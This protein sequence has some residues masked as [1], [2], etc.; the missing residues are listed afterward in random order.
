MGTLVVKVKLLL[1]KLIEGGTSLT[2]R[3]SG[4]VAE[5]PLLVAV[6]V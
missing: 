2:V 4:T 6:T 3:E 5:P 1:P